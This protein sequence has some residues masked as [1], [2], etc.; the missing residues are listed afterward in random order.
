MPKLIYDKVPIIF[1]KNN[2]SITN[3]LEYCDL[4]ALKKY[5]DVLKSGYSLKENLIGKFIGDLYLDKVI[6]TNGSFGTVMR[7]YDV[8]HKK[9]YAVKIMIPEPNKENSTNDYDVGGKPMDIEDIRSEMEAF[10]ILSKDPNCNNHILCLYKS[11]FYKGSGKLTEKVKKAFEEAPYTK[12]KN[13][14]KARY[15]YAYLQTELMNADLRDFI[16]GM[17]S[18]QGKEWSK[19]YPEIVGSIIKG[20]LQGVNTIH[21]AGLAH[22]DLKPENILVKFEENIEGCDFYKNPKIENISV[23][24]ADLGFVCSGKKGKG[25]IQDCWAGGTHDYISPELV[26]YYATYEYPIY[27]AQAQDIWALGVILG[28][29]MYKKKLI[30]YLLETNSDYVDRYRLIDKMKDKE[31]EEWEDIWRDKDL[32][33]FYIRTIDSILDIDGDIYDLNLWKQ[34]IT[35]AFDYNYDTFLENIPK[36]RSFTNKNGKDMRFFDSKLNQIFLKM[37]SYNPEMRGEVSTI[38]DDFPVV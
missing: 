2:K 38:L 23:R 7:G 10:K 18:Y 33:D 37:I 19:K 36:Y 27:L 12:N 21:K 11:G 24:I 29:L 15:N 30:E 13:L 35:E 31:Y 25:L 20:L 3:N 34:E 32:E 28:E 8:F 17:I 4:P 9:F 16:E 5:Y 6:A 1:P 26:L 22:M 14:V